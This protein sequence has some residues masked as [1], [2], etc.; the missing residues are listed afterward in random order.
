MGS[1]GYL[2]ACRVSAVHPLCSGLVISPHCIHVSALLLAPCKATSSATP[3]LA[4][5]KNHRLADHGQVTRRPAL[6]QLGE[7]SPAL[8]CILAV[9]FLVRGLGHG[10]P[11]PP[12]RAVTVGA[13]PFPCSLET[14]DGLRCPLLQDSTGAA[15][16]SSGFPRRSP[17]NPQQPQK[18]SSPQ[19][20]RSPDLRTPRRR[21]SLRLDTKVLLQ[22]QA[23]QETRGAVW[24]LL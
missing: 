11:L 21:R 24:R 16:W 18:A 10:G 17:A 20:G 12:E 1:H 4:Y 5:G 23:P 15:L 7:G 22:P 2:A 3:G 19:Q 8:S 9:P 14:T 13:L 6:L